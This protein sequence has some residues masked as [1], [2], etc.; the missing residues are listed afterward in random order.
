MRER[1]AASSGSESYVTSMSAVSNAAC[2][3]SEQRPRLDP[4]YMSQVILLPE[5]VEE[6]PL[7]LF[8]HLLD[9][10]FFP[11]APITGWR[12]VGGSATITCFL[13]TIGFDAGL[14][15]PCFCEPVPSPCLPPCLSIN[16]G[17]EPWPSPFSPFQFPIVSRRTHAGRSSLAHPS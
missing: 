8:P 7:I 6:W 1:A 5:R 4:S 11:I 15:L 17:N 16:L 13:V 2:V 9:C 10:G 3:F 12:C 14:S